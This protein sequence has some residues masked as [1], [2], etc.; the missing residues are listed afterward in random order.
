M[1]TLI[2]R[3][4]NIITIKIIINFIK[5]NAIIIIIDRKVRKT[6]LF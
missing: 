6:Q 5:I 2:M 1:I 4:M 3:I